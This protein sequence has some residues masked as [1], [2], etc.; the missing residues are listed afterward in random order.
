MDSRA[1]PNGPNVHQKPMFPWILA[2]FLKNGP[3]GGAVWRYDFHAGAWLRQ[4]PAF[5]DARF[6]R[7]TQS[8]MHAFAHQRF[9]RLFLPTYENT[10]YMAAQHPV[11]KWKLRFLKILMANFCSEVMAITCT[12]NFHQN[13]IF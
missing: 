7:R 2:S 9:L 1:G 13:Q 11:S 8:H 3:S 6:R 5:G 12:S 4:A 10:I